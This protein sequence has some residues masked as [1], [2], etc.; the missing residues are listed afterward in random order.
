MSHTTGAIGLLLHQ[1][2]KLKAYSRGLALQAVA[3]KSALHSDVVVSNHVLNMYAKCGKMSSARQV[4]DEMPQRNLV[5]WSAMI[6]GYDQVAEHWLA[7]E[8]YSQ[9][10]SFLPNEYVFASVI[11]ACAGLA[12]LVE[13]QQ[14]HAQSLK[15]GCTSISFVA[16]ALISMYMKCGRCSDGSLV[17]SGVSDPT[18][19]SYNALISGFADNGQSIDGFKVF[20]QVQRQGLF[21]DEFTFAGILKICSDSTDQQFGAALHCQAMKL[22][23]ESTAFIGNVIIGMYSSFKLI[24]EAEKVFR[25]IKDRDLIS[26][27]TIL[28]TCSNCFDHVRALRVLRVMIADHHD[29]K[30]D[31]FTYSG[32]LAACAGLASLKHG[33]QIHGH[34]IRT[35]LHNDVGVSNSLMNMYAKCGSIVNAYNTFNR[36]GCSRNLVSWNTIIAGYGNHGL[37]NRALELF[38][39]MKAEGMRPDSVTFLTLLTAC[40]HSGL[41]GEGQ[42]CLDS[43]VESYG[44]FPETEHLSCI[45][46]LLG[47]AGRLK[48]AEDYIERFEFGGDPIV[49]GSLLAACVLHGEVPMGER[50][51]KRLL[52]LEPATTSPYVLLSNLYA[53]DEK[54]HGVAE[55]KKLLKVSGLKKEPGHSMVEVNDTFEKFTKG[56]FSHSRILDIRETLRTLSSAEG[57]TAISAG[58]QN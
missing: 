12:A 32:A 31:D 35:R 33:K 42:L 4:F 37:G 58:Y 45:I 36:M 30:P 9:M 16:N 34:L 28:S 13:G 57:E 1:C 56:D 53:T 23:L 39:D 8:L 48:E 52:K 41:V 15:L 26:W 29:L 38:Q 5:S 10:C 40:N 51:G 2:A 19:V 22:N 3:Y 20:S 46:D 47:R 54:W 44:I 27:N 11:S 24:D 50:L 14:L 43:M 55:T 17:H 6:S 7:L 25:T 18:L 21:P 49:L